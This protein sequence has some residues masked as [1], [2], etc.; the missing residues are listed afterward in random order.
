MSGTNT[1]TNSAGTTRPTVVNA[2]LIEEVRENAVLMFLVEWVDAAGA[3]AVTFPR[4]TS[5]LAMTATTNGTT[6][7]NTIAYS[8]MTASVATATPAVKA[9][10]VLISWIQMF[11]SAVDWASEA[12]KALARASTDLMDSDVGALLAGGSNTAGLTGQKLSMTTLND[13]HILHLRVA[14]KYSGSAG[15]VLAPQQVGDITTDLVGGTGPGLSPYAAKPNVLSLFGN[16]APAQPGSELETNLIGT[17]LGR[18]VLMS[19]NVPDMN[20]AADHGGALISPRY[21]LKGAVAWMPQTGVYDQGVNAQPATSFFHT[22]AYAVTEGQDL[23]IV[24]I[25]SK[26]A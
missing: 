6:E 10:A 4:L 21:A 22:V 3:G 24:T 2:A 15:F 1:T 19:N 25:I 18:W 7:A 14:K 12:P 20:T 23:G 26:H 9:A 11:G 17:C 8:E 5:T 16:G 13:A